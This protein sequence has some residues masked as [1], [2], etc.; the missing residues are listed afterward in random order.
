MIKEEGGGTLKNVNI[1][2]GPKNRQ[3]YTKDSRK[4]CDIG[5]R[6]VYP[7]CAVSP[8]SSKASNTST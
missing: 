1:Q 8:I 7:T 2:H 4:D 3:M 5:E 6:V